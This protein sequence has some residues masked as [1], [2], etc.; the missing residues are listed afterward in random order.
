MRIRT[1]MFAVLVLACFA[2]PAAAMRLTSEYS[3]SKIFWRVFNPDDGVRIFGFAE[4]VL[5]NGQSIEHLH[6]AGSFQLEIR[7]GGLH[8]RLLSRGDGV[9]HSDS[10]ELIFSSTGKLQRAKRETVQAT[11]ELVV[12]YSLGDKVVREA[13]RQKLYFYGSREQPRVTMDSLRIVRDVTSVVVPGSG[14][15]HTDTGELRLPGKVTVFLG[16]LQVLAAAFELTTKAARSGSK[17]SGEGKAFDPATRSVVLVG[18]G[19]SAG[20]EFF[21]TVT[22]RFSLPQ[23]LKPPRRPDD[24]PPPKFPKLPK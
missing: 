24:E 19:A 7:A 14:V 17:Y 4:G 3:Q 23:Q 9:I 15:L 8:G 22:A 11:G 16:E 21:V 5:A 18:G 20:I 6:P 1:S 10:E 12:Q 13:F 2:S